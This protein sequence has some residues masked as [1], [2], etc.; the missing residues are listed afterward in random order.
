MIVW[1]P[2][3]ATAAALDGPAERGDDAADDVGVLRLARKRAVQVDDVQLAPALL[4]PVARLRGGVVAVHGHVVGASL[5]EAHALAALEV[6][7]R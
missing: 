7:C 1:M 3:F 2:I 4:A 5:A 6:D